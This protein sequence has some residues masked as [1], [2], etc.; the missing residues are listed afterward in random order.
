MN[1]GLR[2]GIEVIGRTPLMGAVERGVEISKY[3]ENHPEMLQHLI[4]DDDSDM[5]IHMDRLVQSD[6]FIG[7]GLKEY[8]AINKHK[9]FTKE[10]IS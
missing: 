2:E 7:F 3:L 6:H 9:Y 5:T 4:F 8:K 1:G 10:D